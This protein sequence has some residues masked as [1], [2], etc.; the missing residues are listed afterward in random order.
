MSEQTYDLAI[1]GSG[2]AAFAAAIRAVKQGKRVA[3]VERGEVGG[4]CVNVGCIPSKALL[5]AAG[6]SRRASHS[7][8]PGIRTAAEGVDM[9]TLIAVKDDIVADLRRDKYLDLVDDYGW[10]MLR[11]QARFVDG[12]GIEV[13]GRR[14]DAAHYLVATGA[15]P[16]A[17]PIHGL[18]DAQA[19][20]QGIDC[21]CRVLPL[22]YVPRALVNRDTRGLVK[23]VAERHSGV[24]LGIHMLA[25]NAG[26]AILAGVYALEFGMTTKQMANLWSPYLTMAEGI[27]LAAQT[28]TTDVAK[29]S[30]CAA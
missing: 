18:T 14:L 11:G 7:R 8:F 13:D 2:G 16:A 30:C 4:T 20:E 29:L 25:E 22:E 19:Q 9:R 15:D 6:T 5:A 1:V 26:D 3:M 23:I 17:P 28:F 12:P 10:T 21:E 24:I 27:K